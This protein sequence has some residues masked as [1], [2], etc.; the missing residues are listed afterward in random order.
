MKLLTKA[1]AYEEARRQEIADGE[2]PLFHVSPAVGWL[3]DPNGFSVYRG[4]Y[5][6]FYQ[7]Y[8]YDVKWGPMHWGHYKSNDLLHWEPLPAALAPDEPYESGCFSGSAVETDDGRHLLMYTA[9]LEQTDPDGG[10]RVTQGQCVAFGDGRDYQK[11]AGNPVLTARALPDGGSPQDFRDPKLWKEGEDYYA[12]T[13]NRTA[14]GAAALLYT[15][16]DALNWSFVTTLAANHGE[17]GGMWECPDF[18]KLDG[19]A[20]LAVSPMHM[21]KQGLSF[22]SGHGVIAMLGDY[23]GSTHTFTRKKVQTVDYGLDFYAPQ[24]LRTPDGRRIMIGW[25]QAW[26]SSGCVPE[27]SKWFGMLTVPREL[28]VKDGV[29]VQNPVR[30]LEACRFAPVEH[31]N[32]TIQEKTSLEGVRG[33]IID[34]TVII[35]AAASSCRSFTVSLAAD[36]EHRTTVCYD[37]ERDVISVDR[38]LSGSRQDIVHF[39]QMP[40]RKKDGKL[41]LRFLLDRFSMELFVNGGEQAFSAALYETP[42]EADGIFFEADG[43]ISA[44]IIKYGI[45]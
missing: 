16:K 20:V 19:T 24:T 3:N 34:M 10:T 25:M 22:H 8:P 35:D 13:V 21:K 17:F 28:S 39:R 44:D 23:D 9:H 31:R 32:V 11:Y 1:R 7:Y 33:R 41:T 2:R 30:E 5:H 12:V 36:Q 26:A 40:V 42:Q 14:G 37:L 15:S 38:S 43:R 45:R 18:F 29:L 27:G 6:I 4:E